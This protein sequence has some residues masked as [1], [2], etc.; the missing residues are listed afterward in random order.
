MYAR[1]ITANNVIAAGFAFSLCAF[2]ALALQFY[3][4]AI[5]FILLS[6][7]MNGLDGPLARQSQPTD[8][9]GYYGIVSDFI[10]Y[11]GVVFFF[12]LGQPEMALP[13]A[14]LIFSFI[15][16][17]ILFPKYAIFATKRSINHDR[18]E[19]KALFYLGGLTNG[20]VSIA[21]LVLMCCLSFSAN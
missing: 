10:F 11:S 20:T 19:K 6:R 5:V 17:G 1:G 16:A 15:G 12:A 13:A 8:L 9:G 2:A 4:V 21:A 18:L 3:T 7:L 14:C